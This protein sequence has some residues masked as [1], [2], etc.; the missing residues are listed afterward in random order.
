MYYVNCSSVYSAPRVA[1]TYMYMTLGTQPG[2]QDL[3]QY[4]TSDYITVSSL[5]KLAEMFV[6]LIIVHANG[7]HVT[8]EDILIIY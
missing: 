5:N 4:H 8:Y 2:Y 3:T 7:R 6:S 1:P